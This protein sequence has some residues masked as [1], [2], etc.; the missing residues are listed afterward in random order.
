[1]SVRLSVCL[2]VTLVYCIQLAE[3]IV[4]LLYHPGILIILVFWPQRR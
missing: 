3:D 4:K 1:V 2:S